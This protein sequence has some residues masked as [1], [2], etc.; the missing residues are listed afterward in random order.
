[1]SDELVSPR[2]VEE[3]ED[4]IRSDLARASSL[5]VEGSAVLGKLREVLRVLPQSQSRI[6]GWLG[7]LENIIGGI[8][9]EQA[10][11]TKKLL[12]GEPQLPIADFVDAI[13]LEAVR[14]AK[15]S[16]EAA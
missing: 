2:K 8:A 1:M 7:A 6:N 9:E 3:F 12:G 15:D 13:H 5:F 16:E 4:A 11:I 10:D 14:Q